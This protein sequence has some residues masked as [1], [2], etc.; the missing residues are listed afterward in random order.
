MNHK[1]GISRADRPAERDQRIR[2]LRE[3]GATYQQIRATLGLTAREIDSVLGE[4]A[5]LASDGHS[6]SEIA[7]RIGLPRS[8][9][10]RMFASTAQL[11]PTARMNLA[12]GLAVDMYGLQLDVLA[13]FLNMDL[14]HVYELAKQLR[15]A[16]V[17]RALFD[18]P[19][20]P[21]W[22]VPTSSTAATHLGWVPATTWSPPPKDA[23]HYR[24]V[25]QARVML[26]GTDL[27]AWISERRL[28]HEA[29]IEARDR[30]GRRTGSIGH[31]HDGRFHGVVDGT[32]GWW[33]V[34]VELSSKSPSNMDKALRGAIWTARDARLI[35]LLYLFSTSEVADNVLAAVDRLPPQLA[36]L[37]MQLVLRDFDR[38]WAS[39]TTH[40]HAI[41]TS[42]SADSGPL[43]PTTSRKDL[44]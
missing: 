10:Q 12:A 35:G 7:R 38:D 17:V 42:R 8:T 32:Y 40:R 20:G 13:L 21:K 23:G 14:P 33:A 5:T 6:Q 25:A 18:Q 41:R 44:P 2:E 27:D 36:E 31:I 11:R 43:T 28:R 37:D 9:V 22:L 19:P 1:K 3:L 39:F 26:A 29:E 4:A 15:K 24:A 16:G 34:E 30:R